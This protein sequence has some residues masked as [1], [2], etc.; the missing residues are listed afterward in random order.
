MP[1]I[2]IECKADNI[3]I[4][5][6]DYAQG[7]SYARVVDAPFFVTHNSYETRF[8]R[9][10]K[11]KMPGYRQEIGNI[12]INNSTQK[13][14]DKLLNDL[15]VFKEDEFAKKLE[16]CHDII[17]KMEKLAPTE[18]FDAM[19]KI[20]FMKVYAERKLIKETSENVFTQEYYENA[21]KYNPILIIKN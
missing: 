9:V 2:V 6:L 17:L 16:T 7:E 18:A 8:W 3:R 13:E 12:P 10:I 5:E 21:K 1:R 11:D 15:V 19:S 20:L 14:I 4:S